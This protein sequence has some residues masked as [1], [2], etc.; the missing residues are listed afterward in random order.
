MNFAEYIKG[1]RICFVGA[2]PNIQGMGKGKEIDK[3][4][5]VV[6]TNGSVLLNSPEYFRDYG[7][8]IDVL[9]AN[10]QFAREMRPLPVGDFRRR[11]IKWVCFKTISDADLQLYS[12]EMK[13]RTIRKVIKVVQQQVPGALMGCFIFADLLS[14]K[15]KEL[16]ITGVDFF[17]SKK[18]VFEH[19]NYQEYLNGYLPPNIRMQGNE[20]N[21]G[22]KDDGHNML[23]N[24]KYIYGL[25]QKYKNVKTDPFIFDLMHGIIDGRMV[26]T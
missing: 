10:V 14:F 8:R 18:K 12:K 9:Y 1:K 19:D 22:K 4:D 25:F 20:I 7:R 2:C 5:V 17:L 21:A 13:V 16:Y 11:G 15:P 24:T 23:E 6:K 3:Y 26:Q